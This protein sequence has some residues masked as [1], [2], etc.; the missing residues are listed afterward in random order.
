MTG[1]LHM[2]AY[3]V[4]KKKK[5][6]M[7]DPIIIL[8]IIFVSLYI[9]YQTFLSDFSIVRE[10]INLVEWK[11]CFTAG[12]HMCA[13]AAAAVVVVA[14]YIYKLLGEIFLSLNR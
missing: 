14:Q 5:T 4:K 3:T 12:R 13:A 6:Q 11:C 8:V 10:I 7:I 9:A 2:R 1:L